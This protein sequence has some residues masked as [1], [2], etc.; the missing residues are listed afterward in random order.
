MPWSNQS[1]GGGNGSGGNGGGPWGQRGGGPG[2][3]SPWGSGPQGGED[4]VVVL[5]HRQDQHPHVG[6][7]LDQPPGGLDARQPGHLQVHQ[8]DV[9]PLPPHRLDA[10]LAAALLPLDAPSVPRGTPPVDA[11]R[12][13]PSAADP[14][15]SERRPSERRQARGRDARPA[16]ADDQE[17]RR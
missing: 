10:R 4:R 16:V 3:K 6:V 9:R 5:D 17:A 7:E 1:G 8:H 14:G 13:A 12:Q 2:G 11:P 15:P